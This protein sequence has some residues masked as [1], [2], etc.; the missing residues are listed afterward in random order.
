MT[1]SAPTDKPAVRPLS[2]RSVALTALLGIHP[3]ELPVSTLVRIGGSFGI[4]ERTTRV[5]LTRMVADGDLTA[6]GGVYRLTERLATRQAQQ[7]E[8]ISPSTRRWDGSWEM[9]IVTTDA[10]TLSERVTLRKT[11]AALR[12]AELREGVW[13]RPAN[14]LRPLDDAVVE[15][16]C[17][18]FEARCKNA[19]DLAQTLWDF[20]AWAAEARRVHR[21]LDEATELTAGLMAAT[22]VLR[23]LRSDPVLPPELLPQDW[24]GSALRQRFTDFSRSYAERLH[25]LGRD[26]EEIDVVTGGAGTSQS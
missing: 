23:H 10:R 13:T 16:Q 20:P 18:F 15:Q 14:L 11:M 19:V 2:A 17:S 8:S 6:D 25:Q 12:L 4:A 21:L 26:T 7:D 9:A 22:E 5:A 3:P 1:R 24:P